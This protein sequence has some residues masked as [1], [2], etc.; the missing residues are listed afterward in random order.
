MSSTS[1]FVNIQGRVIQRGN[2]GYE[3]SVYQYGWSS[4][5]HDSIIEPHAI[6]Y[7]ENDGDV[8]AAINYVKRYEVAVAVCTGGHHYTCASSTSGKNIQ[9]DLSSTYRDF[10]WDNADF[11][12]V[13]LGISIQL[14]KFQSK[15]R[16]KGR[17][18]PTG[19]CSFVHLGGHIQTGGY[20]QLIHSF[21]LL[22]DYIKR[23]CIITTDG[24]AQWVKCGV[25]EDEDLLYAILGGSPGNFGVITHVTLKVLKDKD[26]PN[27]RGF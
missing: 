5:K 23:I 12:E 2:Q 21:G 15:L 19:L 1:P 11:S 25:T 24:M 3:K 17:F 27:S 22:A 20:G 4:Y 26:H 8:I 7:A 13:T 14:G 6:I 10:N 16:E 18:V 9:L